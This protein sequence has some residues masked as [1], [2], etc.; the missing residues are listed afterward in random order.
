MP[1][2]PD[3]EY[4]VEKRYLSKARHSVLSSYYWRYG[5][6]TSIA[7]INVEKGGATRSAG[8]AF[9]VDTVHEKFSEKRTNPRLS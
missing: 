4:E 9:F 5:H 6:D 2:L 1:I 7:N 8:H 3:D